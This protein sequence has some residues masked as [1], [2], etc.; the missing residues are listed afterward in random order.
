MS[1][2]NTYLLFAYCFPDHNPASREPN[3]NRVF[4][5]QYTVQSPLLCCTVKCNV[6]VT[7]TG[8]ESEPKQL[9]QYQESSVPLCFCL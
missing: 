7:L 2:P 5:E 4:R 1:N 6:S 9:T 8:P 3:N